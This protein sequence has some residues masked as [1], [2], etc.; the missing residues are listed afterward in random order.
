M[1][2]SSR[3]PIRLDGARAAVLGGT[4]GRGAA[5]AGTARHRG[6]A[7]AGTVVR[8]AALAAA[9]V[10]AATILAPAAF[11][12]EIYYQPLVQL[13]TAYNT[14]VELDPLHKTGAEGYFA[15][16]STIVG[17]ATP[18]SETTLQ[19]RVLYNYY[20]SVKDLDRLEGFLNLNSRYSWQRDRF[21]ITGFFDHRDDTNAE[22]PGA[23]VNPVT[24][25]IGNTTPTT[26]RVQTGTTRNWL[27]LDPT[28]THL[29]TPLKSIGV[30]AEYQRL[31]FSPEDTTGHIPFNYYLGRAFY[32]WTQNARTDY[33]VSAFGSRY[34]AGTI[35]SRS[36]SEGVNGTMK[37]NWTQTLHS[38]LSG[39]Y[40]RSKF[41]ETSPNTFNQTSNS[42]AAEA[43]TIYTGPIASYRV[44]IGRS[45]VPSAAGGLY[46]TDQLRG[47]YDSDFTERLHF[48]GAVRYFRDRTIA[49][50]RGNDTRDYLTSYVNLKWMMTRTVFLAGSYSYT[51]QKYRADPA[52]A[53]ANRVSFTVGYAGL[54]RQR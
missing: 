49:G 34:V 23:Q 31:T 32:S 6:A 41:E 4:A 26:G 30:A 33:T 18:D 46:A 15:D 20:P 52:S 42:W 2:L 43:S 27:I 16:A 19:P 48:T 44:S 37:Y 45:I 13:S 24:P 12:A 14:N 22:Q 36:T 35:D 5:F 53:D 28:F 7:L 25:D 21:N 47:Q 9:S 1:S 10:I 29:I 40:E 8:A 3:N 50:F 39:T 54:G 17:I 11:G 51:R 38:E